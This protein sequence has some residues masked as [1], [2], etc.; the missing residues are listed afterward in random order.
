MQQ[1]QRACA[2]VK[3]HAIVLLIGKQETLWLT[4]SEILRLSSLSPFLMLV[5]QNDDFAGT[6]LLQGW[7]MPQLQVWK[8]RKSPPWQIKPRWT[9]IGLRS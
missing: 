5:G 6:V 9:V 3:L 2:F 8:T 7:K 4:S 1:K